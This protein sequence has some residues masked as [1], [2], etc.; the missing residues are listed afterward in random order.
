MCNIM[1]LCSAVSRSAYK[2]PT[3]RPSGL[4]AGATERRLEAYSRGSCLLCILGRYTRRHGRLPRAS[5]EAK[6]KKF[7]DSWATEPWSARLPADGIN[8]TRLGNMHT[9]STTLHRRTRGPPVNG[10]CFRVAFGSEE[11]FLEAGTVA[12]Q[13][14]KICCVQSGVLVAIRTGS[15]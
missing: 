3:T 6:A 12:N 5:K 8:I 4:T 10:T 14:Y 13:K 15:L 7:V 1:T 2:D 11:G 9:R